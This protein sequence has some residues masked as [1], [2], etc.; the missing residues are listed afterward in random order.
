MSKIGVNDP[1]P[2]GSGKKY[3]RCCKLKTTP[4]KLDEIPQ[5][6]R[7][8]LKE[9]STFK[10]L[11]KDSEPFHRYYSD[12]RPQLTNF[13]VVHDS[14]LP[15]GIRARTTRSNGMKYL[16]LRTPVCPITDAALIAHELGH[17]LLDTTGFPCVGGLNDHQ[18][19]A[20]LNSAL[21]DPLVDAM[22][23]KCEFDLT[24]D[25]INEVEESIRT[26]TGI[27]HAPID[28]AGKAHW[29]ANFMGHILYLNIN[30]DTH[31][32]EDYFK[33]FT[34]RYPSIASEAERIA[35]KVI[36]IGFDTPDKMFNALSEARFMLH[37][38]GGVIMPPTYS[39]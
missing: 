10:L 3:K 11:L 21:Q 6:A 25:N 39:S 16:R 13:M 9:E 17:F 22:L 32:D 27:P 28:A 34:E 7:S 12:V 26:L 8:P 20:A 24:K 19:A 23:V 14:G 36:S 31:A 30:G 5:F 29:I 1:C 18:A 38:G 2:C 4:S 35:E 33:W 37:A 15:N